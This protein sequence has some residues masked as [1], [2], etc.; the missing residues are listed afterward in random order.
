MH[1]IEEAVLFSLVSSGRID[2]ET[3][4][5]A[6]GLD[7]DAAETWYDGRLQD[8]YRQGGQPVPEQSEPATDLPPSLAAAFADAAR[9]KA[10]RDVEGDRL[11]GRPRHIM[12]SD[13]TQEELDRMNR[14][15]KIPPARHG[16]GL[17]D[18]S[19]NHDYYLSMDLDEE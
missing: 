1:E 3:A 18:V 6:L 12:L 8:L 10:E 17:T 14:F 13:L 15:L 2:L 11:A 5:S 16:S 4:G 7:R 9:R 19:I